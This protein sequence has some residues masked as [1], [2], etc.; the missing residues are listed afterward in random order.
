[1]VFHENRLVALFVILK[2]HALFVI[3]K[4]QQRL[5]LSS[6]ANYWWHLMGIPYVLG[7]NIQRNV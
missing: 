6:A 5:K 4:K 7:R 1:M 2:Y 3:L